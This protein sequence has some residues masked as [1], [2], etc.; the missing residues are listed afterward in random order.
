MLLYDLP[1]LGIRLDVREPSQQSD[2][3]RFAD[4]KSASKA[5]HHGGGEVIAVGFMPGLAYSPF[6]VGQTTLDEEWPSAPRDTP[7]PVSIR[8]AELGDVSSTD[9]RAVVCTNPD[10]VLADWPIDSSLLTGPEGSAIVLVNH[11]YKPIRR[12]RISLKPPH[13][14]GTAIS[15]EGV[16]VELK[17]PVAEAGNTTLEMPLEWTDIVL[18]PKP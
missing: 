17:R 18:L 6:K 7:R 10:R 1:V 9:P 14:V 15:T 16:K 13:P 4:G 3:A 12:L 8:R 2:E 5:A 11:G